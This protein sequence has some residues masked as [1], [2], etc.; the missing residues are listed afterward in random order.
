MR[1][2]TSGGDLELRFLHIGCQ[3]QYRLADRLGECRPRSGF[4]QE[5]TL[6][7]KLRGLHKKS[8]RLNWRQCVSLNWTRFRTGFEY[9]FYVFCRHSTVKHF[10][11]QIGTYFFLPQ[12]E[13]NDTHEN[14]PYPYYDNGYEYRHSNNRCQVARIN[15]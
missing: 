10:P 5:V 7:Q 2:L 9:C 8:I 14:E 15:S 6:A 12:L 11:F 13:P 4:A 3:R 1:L